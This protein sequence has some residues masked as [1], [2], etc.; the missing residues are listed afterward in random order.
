MKVLLL[1]LHRYMPLVISAYST[2]YFALLFFVDYTHAEL[3]DLAIASFF[4]SGLGWITVFM[5]EEDIRKLIV[6]V[7]NTVAMINRML[8]DQDIEEE[9]N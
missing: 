4:L 8:E 3:K 5:V 6:A 9:I 7:Q 2:A 1:N